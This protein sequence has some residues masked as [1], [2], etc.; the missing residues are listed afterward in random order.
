MLFTAIIS[1]ICMLPTFGLV[2]RY[3]LHMFQL[4]GYKNKEH[5]TWIKKNKGKQGLLVLV[6]IA[7]IVA[8]IIPSVWSL[9]AQIIIWLIVCRYYI[10][11]KNC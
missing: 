10:Y 1:I 6:G 8:L 7:G 4:N 5:M 3:N 11:L 2:L 9:A